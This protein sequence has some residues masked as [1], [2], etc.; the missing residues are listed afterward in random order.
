[1]SR[2]HGA[3]PLA[4]IFVKIGLPN[5]DST[6]KEKKNYAEAFSREL[7][8]LFADQVRQR[9]PNARVTP[10]LD[11]KEQEFRIGGAIDA[12][13][14]DVTV[15][16]DRAGLI[17]GVSI[18]TITAMDES[19]QRYTKNMKRN[20]M[21]LRDEADIL[22][23]RQ[24][25]AYLTAVVL[26]PMKSTCDGR[27]NNAA[28]SFAHGVFTFRKRAGRESPD[29][30]R[31]DLFERVFIGL[32]EDDGAVGFF[33][34]SLAPRKNQPPDELLSLDGLLDEIDRQSRIRN[35]GVSENEKY[36]D[37]DPTWV[38]PVP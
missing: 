29:S 3:T 21:E 2:H 28:S 24:P 13:K 10:L 20:D 15:W 11:G 14:T 12:K 25:Y 26:L 32:F 31:Y 27:A 18:K 6:Q 23:R 30:S 34:T 9:Y 33:D 19:S 37:D 38:P 1:M 17:L 22:H 7:A 5:E 36:A 16:D 4:E 35:F 8:A